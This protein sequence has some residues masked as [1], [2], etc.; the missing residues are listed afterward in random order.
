MI[1]KIFLRFSLAFYFVS[2]FTV[3]VFAQAIDVESVGL[4]VSNM[5]R[6]VKFYSQVLSFEKISDNV[7]E[8]S[9]PELPGMDVKKRVVE[10][11]LDEER[12]EL[13][14]Y[15]SPKGK[16]APQDSRSNDHWFQHIAIIVSD[17]GRA[18]AHLK[19]HN[20]E[21]SS[22]APQRLPDWNPNAGGIEAFYFKDPDG[23][24]LEILAFP[25]D[26][27]HAK[28]HKPTEKL[29]LGIDHTAIVVA[30][31]EAGLKF[32]R[33]ILGFHVAGE[34]LNYGPEQ[35]RLNNVE[36]ARLRITGLAAV[37]GPAVEFLEYL[38][39]KSGRPFLNDEKANDLVH[40]HTTLI[41][42][43][44][45]QIESE[46]RVGSYVWIT[47]GFKDF[48]YGKVAMVRDPSGHVMKLI[49]NQ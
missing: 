26:K 36:G 27:G 22:P 46:L 2:S 17:I 42:D 34:S 24:P 3:I 35:E 9:F 23:H 29:F 28:W 6:S 38:S 20:V 18:Y 33:D 1:R 49:D 13:T 25:P 32:Y 21:H 10:M 12:I 30:D 11:K 14:E 48:P 44:H 16:P 31:T 43:N 8:G 45:E 39:P 15:L 40:W 19:E 41:V 5:E 4:T 37:S 47:D 7:L